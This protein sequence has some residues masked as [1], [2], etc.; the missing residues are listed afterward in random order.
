MNNMIIV[1]KRKLEVYAEIELYTR[2]ETLFL[3]HLGL[4]TMDYIDVEDAVKWFDDVEN[5]DME[6][7]AFL[8]AIKQHPEY[9]D[10]DWVSIV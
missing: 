10:V 4:E 5:P 3:T 7:L 8:L 6:V 9:M 2:L 1:T